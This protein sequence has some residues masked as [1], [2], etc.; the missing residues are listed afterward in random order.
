MSSNSFTFQGDR[1]KAWGAV[2]KMSTFFTT[3]KRMNSPIL[4]S[5]KSEWFT[6][7][8]KKTPNLNSLK[9]LKI[10]AWEGDQIVETMINSMNLIGVPLPLPDVLNSLQTGIV[11]AAYAPP[12]EC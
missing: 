8:K 3:L 11:E 6:C 10:W 4:V 12:W 9:G 5:L 1:K 7:F 2:E